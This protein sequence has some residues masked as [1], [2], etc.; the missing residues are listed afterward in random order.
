MEDA[1]FDIFAD[2]ADRGVRGN[3]IA[4]AGMLT[5]KTDRA[6]IGL[7]AADGVNRVLDVLH[8]IGAAMR[9]G[10][11]LLAESQ[12]PAREQGDIGPAGPDP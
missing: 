10:L 11:A 3:K 5:A 4:A 12:R 2:E 9:A 1:E 6:V 8:A 7:G